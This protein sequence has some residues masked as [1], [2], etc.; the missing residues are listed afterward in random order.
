MNKHKL[1]M[2]RVFVSKALCTL[3]LLAAVATIKAQQAPL[4]STYFFNKYL[5]NPAFTGIDNE[6]RAFGFYRSQWA[7][8]PGSPVTGGATLEGSFWK[9]RIGVGAY[10]FNDKIGVFNRTNAAVSYAQKIKFAKHHQISIGVQGGAFIN[11]I[12]FSG[13][14]A[15][16]YNDP[17]LANLKPVRAVFD[18]NIGISYQWK[19]LL[20]G[21]SVPNV[22][23]PN[24]K[25]ANVYGNATNYQYVRHY[26][27]FLQ[28]KIQLFKGK[29]NITPTV[30][31]RKARATAFQADMSLMLD[32]KNIVFIGAGYRNMFGVTG[33]AGVNILNMFTV[34][35]AYDYTT[36]R[37]LKGQVGATHEITAGFHIATDYKP[38]KKTEPKELINQ[39]DIDA[40]IKRNDTLSAKLKATTGKLNETEKEAAVLNADNKELQ[41]KVDSLSRLGLSSNTATVA[42]PSSTTGTGTA[43]ATGKPA[44]TTTTTTSSSAPARAAPPVNFTG[45]VD[46]KTTS[47]YT[48]NEIYFDANRDELLPESKK[49]L[50]QLVGYLQQNPNASIVVKG[51]TDNTG[52][53]DYNY[54][55]SFSRAKAVVDYLVSKGIDAGRLASRGYGSQ[56]PVTDNATEEGRKM[57]RRVEFTIGK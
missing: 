20:V 8:V 37:I 24:A 14:H 49:Q 38:K 30:V 33:M 1:I 23:Q 2:A 50:D 4:F 32:Y 44:A 28:Y 3:L 6:Y 56:D 39:Q 52:E 47:T 13:T 21:F 11:R 34:A 55:L 43:S 42:A 12:N 51:Y 41:A 53:D 27:A 16:D 10:V 22:I 45:T 17:D 46:E 18:L 9:N 40:V 7:D 15:A 57:N 54:R 35:Y 25:Y 36:Q 5:N 31:M 19:T 29:F 26:T 48:L